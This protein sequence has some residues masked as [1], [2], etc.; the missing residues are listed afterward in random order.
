MTRCTVIDGE[1]V[2]QLGIRE[3]GNDPVASDSPPDGASPSHA[4]SENASMYI[5]RRLT[6][7]SV[8]FDFSND[9]LVQELFLK[10]EKLT[11]L[12]WQHM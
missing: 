6:L 3:N 1:K 5:S 11:S 12:E 4:E 8:L 2:S 7:L 10:P 9:R